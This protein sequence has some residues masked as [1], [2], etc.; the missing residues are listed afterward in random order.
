MRHHFHPRI[1]RHLHALVPVGQAA[2]RAPIALLQDSGQKL[3]LRRIMMQQPCLGDVRCPRNIG[4]GGCDVAAGREEGQRLGED[5]RLLILGAGLGA[6][7]PARTRGLCV[8][9]HAGCSTLAV[10]E[11]PT[12]H[13]SAPHV[14]CHP[15]GAQPFSQDA[16]RSPCPAPPPLRR[17]ISDQRDV[18]RKSLTPSFTGCLSGSALMYSPVSTGVKV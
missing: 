2:H 16:P 6:S 8:V 3:V 5:A 1:E 13:H 18:T 15:I 11:L 17:Q 12:T 9:A 14:S 10:T 4:Q 7:G